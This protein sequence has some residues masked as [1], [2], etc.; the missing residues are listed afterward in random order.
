MGTLTFLHAADLH[1]DS[2]LIGLDRYEGAPVEGARLATRRAFA[3]LVDLAIDRRVDFVVIAGDVYDGDWRDYNTG[4]YF[5]AQVQRLREAGIPVVLI[6]G[7]HDAANRMTRTLRLPEGVVRLAS[8]APTSH[9]W[10][11]WGVV[12]H[13]QSFAQA[14]VTEDLAARY[15]PAR[16]GWFNI[17]LLHTS[18]NG[19]EG[20]A[21]Y[22]PC[23][24][25]GLRYREYEYWALGHVHQR[26]DLSRPVDDVRVHYPG[27][28]QGRH[29]RETG[30]KGCL[31]VRIGE[32]RRVAEVRFEP[33]DVMRWHRLRVDVSEAT[34]PAEAIDRV[35]PDLDRLVTKEPNLVHAAR[36]ELVGTTGAHDRL[37]GQ[38]DRWVSELRALALQRGAGRCWIEKVRIATR[39]P[40]RAGLDD[41]GPIGELVRMID[42]L[43]EDP[44]ELRDLIGEELGPLI[45]KLPASWTMPM[46]HGSGDPHIS[47]IEFSQ[48]PLRVLDEV[49]PLL[50]ELLQD[51]DREDGL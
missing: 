20:H 11:D 43:R 28:L 50:F 21:H 48:D 49:E 12:V 47:P 46:G 15:P 44:T 8:D 33:I 10:D 19:R 25:D 13:G 34:D 16:S 22:A 26:E 36:V 31:L 45:N 17:G 6:A 51:A 41:P 14:A 37:A 5:V 35:G 27:N 4:L 38:S 3:N 24:L 30:A 9:A 2:P 1:L 40:R 18:L 39:P 23:T 32:D 29:A 42:Q 7:N